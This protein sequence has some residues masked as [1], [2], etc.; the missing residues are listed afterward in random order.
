MMKKIS[1]TASESDEYLIYSEVTN[2]KMISLEED[3]DDPYPP[4]AD[5]LYVISIA[6]VY[7]KTGFFFSDISK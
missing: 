5:W 2:I 1:V 4:L 6:P 7:S 3:Q